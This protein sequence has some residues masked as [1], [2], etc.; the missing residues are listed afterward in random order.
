MTPYALAFVSIMSGV[1]G[2]LFGYLLRKRFGGV[3]GGFLLMPHIARTNITMRN[4]RTFRLFWILSP[5]LVTVLANVMTFIPAIRQ[6]LPVSIVPLMV[7]IPVYSGFVAGIFLGSLI[8]GKNI[9]KADHKE[10][11]TDE[12]D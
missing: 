9:L 3:S 1:D 8:A 5:F 2:T 6:T 4:A 12:V 10:G 7:V 11:N